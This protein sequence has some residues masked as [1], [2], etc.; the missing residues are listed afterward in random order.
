MPE[1]HRTAYAAARAQQQERR[2]AARAQNTKQLLDAGVAFTSFDHG[3]HL[4]IEHA[5]HVIDF[6]AGPGTWS[7]LGDRR[8]RYGVRTLINFIAKGHENG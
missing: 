8:K 4:R 2:A 7:L 6:M 1:D 5:G 3:W